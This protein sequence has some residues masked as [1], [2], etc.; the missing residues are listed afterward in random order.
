MG[1]KINPNSLRLGIIRNWSSSW[2]SKGGYAELLRQDF[3]IRKFVTERLKLAGVSRV[4][5]ER[6]AK[7]VV[8]NIHTARP[9]VVIG[10][11]GN[12][13]EKLRS[14]LVK[15]AGSDVALNIIEVRK[16]EIDARLVAESIAAQIEKRVG[17]R[18]AVKRAM[19]STLRAGGLGIRV[20]CSGRLGG[21]EIARMEWYRE[22]Q[23]PLH[24]LRADIDYG[25]STANTTYGSVGIK[26][27]IYRGELFNSRSVFLPKKT[28]PDRSD[29]ADRSDRSERSDRSGRH[30]RHDRHD[31][32]DRSDRT[33]R[34]RE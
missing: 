7:K 19:Q 31:R 14:D 33:D 30:D 29:G 28:S 27:W 11:K 21:A 34:N 20:N 8:V 16:P 32:R 4:N 6:L 1:Q 2:Y 5:L 9:G 3:E 13:I 12:D 22:G 24:T 23:V 15:M 18:R 25:I 26:V 10:K 17:F